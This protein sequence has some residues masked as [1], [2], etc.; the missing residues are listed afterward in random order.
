M[1]GHSEFAPIGSR[2]P[3][4]PMPQVGGAGNSGQLQTGA[5]GVQP[6]E[7]QDVEHPDPPAAR[8]LA[9]K[10]DSMLVKAAKM[11]VRSVDG[12][13]LKAVTQK[14]KLGKAELQ[15]LNAAAEMARQTLKD[16]SGFTGREI[17]SA[18]SADDNGVFDWTQNAAAVAIRA[19]IDAQGR[20]SELLHELANRPGL[21]G[22]V[23]DS[24]FEL[25]MQCDRRQSEI[26]TLAMQ[27][28]D[29][30]ADVDD[31]PDV[32]ARFDAK[33]SA[34][35]PGQV[36]SMHGNAEALEK[37]KEKL[38][39][40]A[41]RLESFAKRPNAS[42][43]SDEFTT[44]AIEVKDACQTL[45]HA[46]KHG[47]L[48]SDGESRV[49]P[50]RD[51]MSA[52]A[53]LA[54]SAESQLQDVRK[55][56]G[57]TVL[58]R[59]LDRNI[60]IPKSLGV[61]G[62]EHSGEVESNAPCL[63][64]AIR[65]RKRI[66]LAAK[67]YMAEPDSKEKLQELYDIMDHYAAIDHQDLLD[68]IHYL[69][70]YHGH[71]MD[72]DGWRKLEA[73]FSPA[74]SSLKT[75]VSHFVRMVWSV[76]K[77]MTA[78]QF[79][80]TSS[81]KAL[82]EGKLLFSTLIEARIHGMS[83][84]DV[85]PALDDSNLVSVDTL[86]SGQ[87]NTVKLVTYKNGSEYV[88]KPEAPG[89]Q[90]MEK[91]TLSQDY[92]SAQMVSQLN[93]A[94]QSTAKALGLDDVVPK[95][96]V[97]MHDGEY[98]LFMEKVPGID[99]SD[100]AKGKPMPGGGLSSKDVAK[101]DTAQRAKVMGGLMRGINRLEWLDLITGQGDRHAHNYFIGVG[102]DLSVTVK[103][104][105]N[106]Q[107]FTAYRTGLRTYVLKG[108]YAKEFKSACDYVIASY[109]K[110]LQRQVRDRL[111]NDPGVSQD[112]E[113]NIVI[114]TA[115]FQ[116]GELH[117]AAR[118]GV[119]MHG[120]TLPDFIDAELY[121]QLMALK[122]GKKRD[123]Y[124]KDLAARLPHKAVDSARQRLDE[125]IQY[126]EELFKKGKVIAKEDFGRQEVQKTLFSREINAGNPVKPV[127]DFQLQR[128]R[129]ND[130][131]RCVVTVASRQVKSLFIRDLYGKVVKSDW[132]K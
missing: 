101:L 85:D 106:D 2:N 21:P 122:S 14:L 6:Q 7:R 65:T 24:I 124:L 8:S 12:D 105:D 89:R 39:P 91:L 48:A 42:L 34:L 104:I 117:F 50:D 100:F 102:K 94:T 5:P 26:A 60:A 18:M 80:S 98:G 128:K 25:A 69:R 59:F 27:L 36:L 43:T 13:S 28:A 71:M 30:A 1:S 75:Q 66:R 83:D 62:S 84:A 44:Y 40:L 127:G 52:L 108:K 46:A 118:W 82:M 95:C 61:A 93:M 56:I 23:F 74:P 114:D 129:T 73:I 92:A 3:Q 33:L 96:S 125:A 41:D 64:E 115:K 37:M 19:A 29:A 81:A 107:C 119:G 35:L 79:L 17:A 78:E 68:E 72:N 38:Q 51:F 32:K 11:S 113:G 54:K 67:E 16:V 88:F 130:P 76:H 57:E 109:P 31:D 111:F 86:G 45:A 77:K 20:L 126:A 53:S 49:I 131:N 47:F 90:A 58:G 87:I 112:N 55:S 120:T 9:Q 10:L 121:A 123:E 97:G 4:I 103:G 22:K 63:A 110:A 70:A 132:F 99:A 15:N 116:A